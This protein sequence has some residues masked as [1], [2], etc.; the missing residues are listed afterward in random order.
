MKV[1]R[2]GMAGV[3]A[4]ILSGST[5]SQTSYPMLGHIEPTA[6]RRGEVVEVM[7]IGAGVRDRQCALFPRLHGLLESALRVARGDRRSAGNCRLVRGCDQNTEDR[8]QGTSTTSAQRP[9]SGTVDHR[10]W[11]PLGPH[12]LRIVAPQG[13]SSVGPIVIVDDPVAPEADDQTNDTAMEPRSWRCRSWSPARLVRLR[14][15]TGTSS[16]PTPASG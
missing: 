1:R 2:V 15:W 16:R 9:G 13:V 4:L 14:T 3:L 11:R 5:R 7:F 8:H 12:E 6:V 10:G